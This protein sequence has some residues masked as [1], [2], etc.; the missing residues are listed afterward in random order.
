MQTKNIVMEIKHSAQN[1]MRGIPTGASLRQIGKKNDGIIKPRSSLEKQARER[2]EQT[3]LAM[4]IGSEGKS[5]TS[6]CNNRMPASTSNLSDAMLPQRLQSDEARRAF[7][8]PDAKL[9]KIIVAL[10]KKLSVSRKRED[11]GLSTSY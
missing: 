4:A 7:N 5:G 3:K 9:S 2:D 8:C 1:N 10:S 11:M 6:C